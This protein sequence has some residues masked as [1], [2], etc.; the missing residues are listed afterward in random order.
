D[1]NSLRLRRDHFWL[2]RTPPGWS[3]ELP[4]GLWRV[5]CLAALSAMDSARKMSYTIMSSSATTGPTPAAMLRVRACA[6]GQFVANLHDFAAYSEP[7]QAGIERVEA[8]GDSA[9]FFSARSSD[10]LAVRPLHPTA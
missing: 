4:A 7:P 1:P 9:P 6:A 3:P 5:V 10:S 2:M 8:A